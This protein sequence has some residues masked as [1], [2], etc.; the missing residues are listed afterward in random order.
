MPTAQPDGE[1][2]LTWQQIYSLTE[3]PE[4]LV[5]VGSGVTGAELAHAYVGLGAQVTLVSSRDRVLPG[6][7][8]DAATVI[9]D[10]F[11]R[12][13][14]QVLGPVAD[15]RRR[16]DGRR[17]MRDA[18]R[19]A[20]RCSARTRCSP[21]APCRRR[22]ESGWWRT[23]SRSPSP[24]T[25][26]STASPGPRSAACMRRATAR[27]SCPWRRWRRCRAASPCRTRWVTRWRRSGC[28]VVSANIFTSPE[29]ATVGHHPE[30]R[31]R[32]H[33]CAA[34]AVMLPLATN[35]RAKMD[36]F[37]RRVRQGVRRSRRAGRCSAV[38]SWRRG[39]PS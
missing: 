38:S 12:D 5:V 20:R 23:G 34:R 31:R 21:W 17:G 24:A 33:G 2:I 9:E 15:G 8:A 4:H 37:T 7:D 25:S 26:R 32:R 3:L 11:R 18:H 14:M 19:R 10:V 6:E 39:P 22:R 1:R 27:A 16:A 30:R 13:G 28:D 36:R 29:I 35:A